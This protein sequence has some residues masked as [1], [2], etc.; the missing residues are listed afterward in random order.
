MTDFAASE[1][2]HWFGSRECF[3]NVKSICFMAQILQLRMWD[4]WNIPPV[5]INNGLLSNEPVLTPV[6]SKRPSR[7]FDSRT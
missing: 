5:F 2:V 1:S 4:L 3:M 6:R 7:L